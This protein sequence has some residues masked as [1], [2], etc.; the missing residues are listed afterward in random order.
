MKVGIAI[1]VSLNLDIEVFLQKYQHIYTEGKLLLHIFPFLCSTAVFISLRSILMVDLIG[2][3]RLTNG[4][5]LISMCQGISLIIGPPVAGNSRESI[6]N[7]N[8]RH[9]SF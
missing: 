6:S 8:N 9:F 1:I 5:G 4:F 7:T 2:L 3:A